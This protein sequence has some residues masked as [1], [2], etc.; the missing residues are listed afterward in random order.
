M[1]TRSK[2]LGPVITHF[3]ML[4]Y[5][6]YDHGIVT[7]SD[8]QD[9]SAD[10]LTT[11][12]YYETII[13]DPSDDRGVKACDHEVIE[14][15]RYPGQFSA[16]GTSDL[17]IRNVYT[18]LGA[19]WVNWMP[20]VGGHNFV[21]SPDG[22]GLD[23]AIRY[24]RIRDRLIADA[25]HDFYSTNQAD[26]L[27]NGIE[28]PELV[29]SLTSLKQ[30]LGNVSHLRQAF[31]AGLILEKL[32]RRS[33]STKSMINLAKRNKRVRNI[34]LLHGLKAVKQG[35]SDVSNLYLAYS[36]GIAPLIRDM[37]TVHNALRTLRRD[38]RAALKSS[39]KEVSIH[40]SDFGS[41]RFE[42]GGVDKGSKV[43]VD[44][45]LWTLQA[46]KVLRTCT[47]RG[48]RENRYNLKAFAEMDYLI[49]RFVAT[50]PASLGWELTPFSFVVD[51]FVDLRNI[52][53]RLDNLLTGRYKKIRD[54]CISEKSEYKCF[55]H[56]NQLGYEVVED[57]GAIMYDK[58]Y[59][60]Y[61]REPITDYNIVASSG[62]FGKHQALLLGALV[63]QKVTSLVKLLVK[64][65]N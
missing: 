16:Y 17:S 34:A 14:I 47:V 22:A 19:S 4:D 25:V 49:S 43:Q 58:R 61:H 24:P 50:G 9:R 1:R 53:D 57:N 51:W 64:Q 31:R 30:T 48:V 7:A 12:E 60:Q 33:R 3:N 32:N 21:L 44:N 55:G 27:V 26:N 45:I 38:M 29:H 62:R 28:A 5:K 11:Y 46:S 59:S 23:I 35:N 6:H 63:H 20:A 56:L 54:V 2:S 41:I 36:F 10:T 40:R 65:I 52:T 42:L 13:D 37:K 39:G 8:L 15:N 18:G